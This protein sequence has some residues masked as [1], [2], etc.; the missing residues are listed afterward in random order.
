MATFARITG[1]L[2]LVAIAGF[3]VFGF[4]AT[5]EPPGFL[6]LRGVYAATAIVCLMGTGWLLLGKR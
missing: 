1:I 6:V 4:L 2:T 5:F 3:C